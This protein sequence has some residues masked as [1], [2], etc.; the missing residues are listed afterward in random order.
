MEEGLTSNDFDL[1]INLVGGDQRL[2]LDEQGRNEI[3]SIMKRR[4]VGF[5]E[6]RRIFIQ[7][8]FAE[9]NIDADGKPRDPKFVSFSSGDGTYPAN[10]VS[11]AGNSLQD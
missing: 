8:R 6:A 7:S 11:D 4:A 3:K 1:S 5:D 2:G 9:N 10:I